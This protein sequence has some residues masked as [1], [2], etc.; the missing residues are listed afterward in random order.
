[1][2]K[3]SEQ[4]IAANEAIIA[5]SDIPSFVQLAR[6]NVDLWLSIE[7]QPGK[8]GTSFALQAP[9]S[10][11]SPAARPMPSQETDMPDLND[12]LAAVQ[13]AKDEQAIRIMD[14]KA[15][16]ADLESMS[17]PELRDYIAEN[18]AGAMSS[19]PPEVEDT[20]TREEV[21]A[22]IESSQSQARQEAEEAREWGDGLYNRMDQKRADAAIQAQAE[23]THDAAVTA[24]RESNPGLSIEEAAKYAPS[25]D[26][27]VGIAKTQQG[28]GSVE[29]ARAAV[30]Q[31]FIDKQAAE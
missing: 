10:T 8:Y 22:E 23:R 24:I 7:G 14:G 13:T 28:T 2:S 9:T 1:M 12:R 29:Q 11:T 27:L 18:H 4:H 21:I 16:E 3:A 20:R 15:T 30:R 5:S 17:A 26:T 25:V 31:A 6:E 19:N